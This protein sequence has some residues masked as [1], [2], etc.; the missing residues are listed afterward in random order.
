MPNALKRGP[1][2]IHLLLPNAAAFLVT[3]RAFVS[4]SRLCFCPKTGP[5]TV[6][7]SNIGR[8]RLLPSS[9]SPDPTTAKVRGELGCPWAGRL[10]LTFNEFGLC[11]RVSV[12]KSLTSMRRDDQQAN[13]KA[14]FSH[15]SF[16]FSIFR[17]KYGCAPAPDLIR[18]SAVTL[19]IKPTLSK[20]L[21]PTTVSPRRASRR[22]RPLLHR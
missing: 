18:A 14:L 15:S 12:I 1:F 19:C 6:F 9:G 3:R 13:M 10:H 17:K 4:T 21:S 16:I 2:D 22:P 11:R 20:N 8:G 5:G 7:H